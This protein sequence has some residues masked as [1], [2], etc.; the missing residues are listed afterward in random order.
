MI[1]R[2]QAAVAPAPRHSNDPMPP[3]VKI[4]VIKAA[5]RT[6]RLRYRRIPLRELAKSRRL[7][8][9]KELD[10]EAAEL[11]AQIKQSYEAYLRGDVRPVDEFMAELEAELNQPDVSEP[12]L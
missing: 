2:F 8:R 3:E 12:R 5:P 6:D 7:C 11:R 10:K 4:F 9:L 1:R